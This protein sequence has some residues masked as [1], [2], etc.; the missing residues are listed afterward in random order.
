MSSGVVMLQRAGGS[1]EGDRFVHAARARMYMGIA[2]WWV[3]RGLKND[4]NQ[5]HDNVNGLHAWS[6]HTCRCMWIYI[7]SELD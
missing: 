5:E 2:L 6:I 7:I 3:V 4:N 1:G